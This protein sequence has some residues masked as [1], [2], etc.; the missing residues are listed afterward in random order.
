MVY[1]NVSCW[2]YLLSCVGCRDNRCFRLCGQNFFSF[3]QPFRLRNF[4]CFFVVWAFRLRI[5]FWKTEEWVRKKK[6]LHASPFS[7]FLLNIEQ[8]GTSFLKGGVQPSCTCMSPNKSSF[9]FSFSCPDFFKLHFSLIYAIKWIKIMYVWVLFQI[10]GEK[11]C[12]HGCLHASW[13]KTGV[14]MF[15]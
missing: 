2:K 3:C 12:R 7:F 11:L 15:A 9:R 10:E 6:N 5:F 1:L 14:E 8:N 13:Q 4:S